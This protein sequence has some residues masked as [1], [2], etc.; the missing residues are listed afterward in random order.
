MKNIDQHC[1]KFWHMYRF[2]DDLIAMNDSKEFENSLEEIYP[3]ELELK[4]EYANDNV[5]T[6]LDL[7]ITI[8][9]EDVLFNHFCR[10]FKNL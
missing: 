2:I 8:N 7:N 6:F 4:K 9:E 3:R 1:A 5:E 10:K